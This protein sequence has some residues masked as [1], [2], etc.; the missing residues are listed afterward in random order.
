[1]TGALG[2]EALEVSEMLLERTAQAILNDDFEGFSHCFAIPHK[3]DTPDRKV[4]L[5]TRD[6]LRTLFQGVVQ[7]YKNRNVTA[8]IRHC[9]VAEFRGPQKVEATHVSHVMSGHQRVVD[10]FHT[11]S[12]MQFTDNRWQISAT[13]Y[14]LDRQIPVG[15]TLHAMTD[16]GIGPASPPANTETSKKET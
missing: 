6:A 13:Q 14:T 10:P 12:V 15:A 2:M 11:Y 16:F 4:T 8:L 7:D 3:I 5:E 9:E 1:M